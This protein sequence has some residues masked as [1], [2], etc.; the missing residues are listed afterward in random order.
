MD[1][2]NN[3]V[4]VKTKKGIYKCYKSES[5]NK[6]IYYPVKNKTNGFIDYTEIVQ[7]LNEE[8]LYNELKK[9][10]EVI[11][12]AVEYLNNLTYW[13]EYSSSTICSLEDKFKSE[14]LQILE[15]KEVEQ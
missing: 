6:P 4:Y 7:I 13:Y 10:D 14:L 5:M 11:E 15:D 12:K 1:K 2:E 3:I 9:K 8:Y